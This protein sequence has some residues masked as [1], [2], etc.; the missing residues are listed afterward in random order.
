MADLGKKHECL[1]CGA[2]FYDLGNAEIICP[3]CGADQAELSAEE[4]TAKPMAKGKKK[5]HTSTK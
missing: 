4:N 2:K 1:S 3:K 5:A